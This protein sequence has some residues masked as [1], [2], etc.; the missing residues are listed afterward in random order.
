[1]KA[2][3]PAP[4]PP[5]GVG[6]PTLQMAGTFSFSQSA[7]VLLLR[8]FQLQVCAD[9][10]NGGECPWLVGGPDWVRKE[11]FAIQAKLPAGTTNYSQSQ[12]LGG[13][14]P[15]INA[16]LLNLLRERFALKTH[17]ESRD[18]PAFALTVNRGGH[19]LKPT[20]GK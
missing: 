15:E 20:Q 14:A 2:G 19:K 18:L 1:G 17:R 5:P 13:K 4:P 12:F 6:P 9:A 16:M 11:S 10:V 7:Y 3:A 8:A